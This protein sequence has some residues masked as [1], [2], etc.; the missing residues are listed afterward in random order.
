MVFGVS[1]RTFVLVCE[2]HPA[3]G[4]TMMWKV[5]VFGLEFS[6]SKSQSADDLSEKVG[7]RSLQSRRIG[8][9]ALLGARE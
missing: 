6:Y 5:R 1:T 7:L 3:I 8:M 9:A 2:A 4:S